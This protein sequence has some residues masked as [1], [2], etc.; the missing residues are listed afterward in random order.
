M[1]DDRC[2]R[3][4]SV[5]LAGRADQATELGCRSTPM[6]PFGPGARPSVHGSARARSASLRPAGSARCADRPRNVLLEAGGVGQEL[7][8]LLRT[9][10]GDGDPGRPLQGLLA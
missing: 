5:M 10:A 8:A 7:T 1:A 2:L 4:S 3:V 9:A 6:P